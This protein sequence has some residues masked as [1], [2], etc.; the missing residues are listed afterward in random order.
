MRNHAPRLAKEGKPWFLAVNLVNPHDVMF[1][2]TDAVGSNLQDAIKPMLG[3]AHPPEDALY[4]Q[5]WDSVPLAASC[6]QAHDEPGRPR[7][8]CSM[9]R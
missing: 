9:R 1:V 3:H 2:N 8:A 7:T 5:K 6:H 4:Q